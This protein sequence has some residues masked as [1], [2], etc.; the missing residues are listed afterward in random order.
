[1]LL[2]L[3][4]RCF[5][6]MTPIEVGLSVVVFLGH[7]HQ[8]HILHIKCHKKIEDFTV[9][10][11]YLNLSVCFHL[12]GFEG[13]Q[14]LTFCTQKRQA[15]ANTKVVSRDAKLPKIPVSKPAPCLLN[16]TTKSASLST[17]HLKRN[18]I[19][20]PGNLCSWILMSFEVKFCQIFCIFIR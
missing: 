14:A 12:L 1:M 2:R 8:L 5:Q 7:C 11:C 15:N 9:S 10:K 6:S 4:G 17:S 3:G 16:T 20:Q 13:A 18:H 19:A